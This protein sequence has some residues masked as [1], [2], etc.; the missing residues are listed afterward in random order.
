M[1]RAVLA[2]HSRGVVLSHT[3]AA[4]AW[5][6][7]V[8]LT[9]FG[10]VNVTGIG[11]AEPPQGDDD[12]RLHGS[13][14]GGRD[15]CTVGGLPVTSGL[16]TSVDCGRV[17]SLRPAVAVADAAAHAGLLPPPE[18]R[19]VLSEMRGWKGIGRARRALE[20]V[21]PDTESPGETWTRLTL[22]DIG[23]RVRSQFPVT[24]ADGTTY[25]AD[26]LIEGTWVIVEFDGRT[27]YGMSGN[28][29]ETDLW[30][31]KRRHDAITMAGYEIVRLT[32]EDLSDPAM[33]RSLIAAAKHRSHTRGRPQ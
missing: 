33:V 17:L 12:F 30:L 13:S 10:P 5:G 4:L 29:V 7:P 2:T 19:R 3:T 28:S 22:R 24:V 6:F 11:P 26:F 32:W 20:L 16:R 18:V 15:T 1:A 9:D 8:M 23:C 14:L 21:D 31:E 25:R 27:K